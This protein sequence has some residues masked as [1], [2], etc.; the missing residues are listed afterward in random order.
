M[1]SLFRK[2]R[3]ARGQSRRSRKRHRDCK[4]VSYKDE[5]RVSFAHPKR[6]KYKKKLSLPK[7]IFRPYSKEANAAKGEKRKNTLDSETGLRNGSSRRDR[8]LGYGQRDE[9]INY[10][11][12]KTMTRTSDIHAGIQ[13]AILGCMLDL[14]GHRKN[15]LGTKKQY[16]EGLEKLLEQNRTSNQTNKTLKCTHFHMV[17]HDHPNGV[18]YLSSGPA[19]PPQK[20]TP[21]PKYNPPPK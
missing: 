21:P 14:K 19:P 20:L 17:T 16:K 3:E 12:E 18:S 1:G 10:V 8:R 13:E 2:E 6:T 15:K 5:T 11:D 9:C 7:G 4:V